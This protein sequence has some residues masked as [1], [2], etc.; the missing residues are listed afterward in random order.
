M[1]VRC[2]AREDNPFQSLFLDDVLDL[3]DR[4]A[5]A[6]IAVLLD[7]GYLRF[8]RISDGL[9][10]ND[11]PNVAAAL[12]DPD[13]DSS[14]FPHPSSRLEEPQLVLQSTLPSVLRD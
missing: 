2:A 6:E 4:G 13:A 14:I 12:A 11:V 3:L 10:V 7:M 9:D 1:H 8:Q 5:G